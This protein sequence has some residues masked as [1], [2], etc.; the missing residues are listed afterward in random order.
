MPTTLRSPRHEALREF[1]V[2][3]R[4]ASGITQAELAK[5][6][7]RGQSF[8]ADVE[9]GERRV[10]LVQFLDFAD[11]LGFDASKAIRKIS[12]TRPR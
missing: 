4:R 3:K 2:Q 5:R 8:V 11:G 1:L 10:D 7:G 12:A 6:I 9:R